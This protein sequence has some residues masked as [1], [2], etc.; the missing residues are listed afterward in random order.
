MN[1]KFVDEFK[2]IHYISDELGRGGQGIVYKTRDSDVAIKIALEN[3]LEI[4]DENKIKLFHKKVRNIIYKPLPLDIQIAK[5]LALLDNKAGYVMRLLGNMQPFST[6]LPSEISKE[7]AEKIKI[8]FFL[9]EL[10]NEDLRTAQYIALYQQT[11]SLRKRLFVLSRLAITLLRLHVRGIVYF[12]ISHNNIFITNDDIPIVYLIDVDNIEYSSSNKSSIYTPS[13][14]AP[15]VVRGEPN[16]LYSDLYAFGILAFLTISM[17]HPFD[18]EDNQEVDWDSDT[19]DQKQQWELPWI[20]NSRDNSNKGNGGLRGILTVTDKLNKLFH[21]LFEDGQNDKY[22]RPTLPLWIEALEK[23][24]IKTIRCDKCQMTYYDDKFE[25][26]PYCQSKKPIR[27]VIHSYLYKDNKKLDYGSYNYVKEIENQKIE[28]PSYMFQTFNI[29]NID[30]VYLEIVF[31]KSRAEFIF[32]Q[33]NEKIYFN[34]MN[35]PIFNLR[36]KI[37]LSKLK[38]GII[39]KVEG[40]LTRLVE[41]KVEE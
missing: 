29:L 30:E 15:E 20:E 36:K 3:E 28:I 18:G 25:L 1:K 8:P 4:T 2:N 39:I 34:D 26:C 37:G 35:S 23:A 40:N 13:F 17:K 33:S 11:G 5:P 14:E 16:S 9:E 38:N 19:T 31:R 21:Q 24:A 32:N 6:I 10:G 41:I 22:K 12:D 27:I 7:D